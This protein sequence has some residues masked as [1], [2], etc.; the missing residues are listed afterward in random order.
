M[1]SAA[2]ATCSNHLLTRKNRRCCRQAGELTGWP[3]RSALGWGDR[4]TRAQEDP[5]L[6]AGTAPAC[7][8]PGQTHLGRCG[9]HRCVRRGEGLHS[10]SAS[11]GS[12]GQAGL[13]VCALSMRTRMCVEQGHEEKPLPGTEPVRPLLRAL[14]PPLLWSQATLMDRDPAERA[15]GPRV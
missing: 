7:L 14:P 10:S 4:E 13:P 1:P 11:E 12:W 5:A 3:H 2:A 6:T 15:G 9:S 8:G